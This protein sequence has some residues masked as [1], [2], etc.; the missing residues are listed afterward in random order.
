[1]IDARARKW[2][3]AEL[4]LAEALASG[5][6]PRRRAEALY[7]RGV[8]AGMLGHEAQS[9][10]FLKDALEAGLSLDQSREARLMLADTDFRAGRRDSAREAYVK[11]VAEGACDRMGAAKARVVGRFL[12]DEAASL[13][14]GAAADAA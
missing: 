7:W 2:S 8:A 5:K 9:V 13:G 14:D 11:L 1:M 3:A 4:S 6:N 12:L 10:G